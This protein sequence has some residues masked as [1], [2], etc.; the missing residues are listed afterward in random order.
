METNQSRWRSK[1][2][3]TGVI[4]AII[5]LAGQFGLYD[6]LG[7]TAE[8]LQTTLDTLLMLAVV[9]GVVNNPTDKADW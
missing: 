7:I 8:W 9:L 2:L 6:L 1:Y 3:W 5:V 4:S